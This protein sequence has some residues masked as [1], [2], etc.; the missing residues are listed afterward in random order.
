MLFSRQFN[1]IVWSLRAVD[2]SNFLVVEE[3]DANVFKAFFTVFD[4]RTNKTVL[5]AFN[6]GEDWWVT[7]VAADRDL[8]L[9]Q[10][11]RHGS[12]PDQ[13]NLIAVDLASGAERWRKDGMAFHDLSGREVF[14]YR[15]G[16]EI[17]GVAVDRQT[18]TEMEVLPE[19]TPGDQNTDLNLPAF[20]EEGTS[21]NDTCK[22]FISATTGKTPVGAIEYL[23]FRDLVFMGFYHSENENLANYLLGINKSGE[24]VFFCEMAKGVQGQGIETFFVLKGCLIFVKNK[25]QLFSYQLI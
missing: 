6:P 7:L 22:A 10:T 12:N 9:F 25:T 14:C 19:K 18:G 17:T 24:E 8:L 16:Q 20:Y 4:Y 2:H 23:E 1:R 15:V 3:R 5:D 21:H 11:Y 13:K